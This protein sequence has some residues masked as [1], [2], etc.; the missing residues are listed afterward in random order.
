M[1]YGHEK[2]LGGHECQEHKNSRGHE[3]ERRARKNTC[4]LFFL[5]YDRNLQ[6]C[7]EVLSAKVETPQRQ[8]D[9]REAEWH[10]MTMTRNLPE[11]GISAT[12]PDSGEEQEIIAEAGID[13]SMLA[14]TLTV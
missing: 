4:D 5:A 1:G 13:P 2:G 8:V 6:R 9:N 7:L 10:N 14:T 3:E 11:P 12:T